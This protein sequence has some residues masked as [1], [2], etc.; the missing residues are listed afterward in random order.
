MGF[1]LNRLF[2]GY[3]KLLGTK[4][5]ERPSI[6]KGPIDLFQI[7]GIIII[8]RDEIWRTDYCESDIWDHDRQIQNRGISR[9]TIKLGL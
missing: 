3:D 9:I 5:K 2:I 4:K 6:G 8:A 1:L 7:A